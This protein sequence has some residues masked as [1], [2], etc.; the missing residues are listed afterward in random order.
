MPE[1]PTLVAVV[2][3][4]DDP[5]L[6]AQVE[7]ALVDEGA[8]V[9]LL[10][11]SESNLPRVEALVPALKADWILLCD[12]DEFHESPWIGRKLQ[13]AVAVVDALGYNAIAFQ[14]LNFLPTVSDRID[15]PDV[16]RRMT[17]YDPAWT[18]NRDKIICWK[19][20]QQR[21]S[22]TRDGHSVEFPQRRVFPLRFVLRHYPLSTLE[23]PLETGRPEG[24]SGSI[25]PA[26]ADGWRVAVDDASGRVRFQRDSSTLVRYDPERV[27][28]D[29]L[30]E[31]EREK[32]EQL[33]REV[34]SL[35]ADLDDL[36]ARLQERENTLSKVLSS[37]SWKLT[38]PLRS[39]DKLLRGQR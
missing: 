28:L 6:F 14:T 4:G 25:A 22:F 7:R 27:R 37:L 29:L 24:L 23:G 1:L 5:G 11:D 8:Q 19:N 16:R 31:P 30:L 9:H 26:R 21:V 36:R 17:F 38:A 2:S 13:A 39:V 34:G 12:A 33:T 3:G 20:T 10:G 15:E 18:F 35:R 32:V